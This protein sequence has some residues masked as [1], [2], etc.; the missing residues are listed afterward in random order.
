M[1]ENSRAVH[2]KKEVV[3]GQQI[4]YGVCSRAIGRSQ[5]GAP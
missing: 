3:D 1:E 4:S 2:V 5:G